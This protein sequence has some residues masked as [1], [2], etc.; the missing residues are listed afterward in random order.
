MGMDKPL[1]KKKWPTKRIIKYS[2]IAVFVL[3]VGY[4]IIF[5]TGGSTLNV[6]TERITV[7]TVEK[8]PFQEYIPI[9]GNVIPK[10]IHYLDASDG[11][12]VEIKY[13]EAGSMVKKGDKIVKLTNTNML[14]TLLN[15]EAEIN[16]ASNDLR[17]T[18]LQLEQ[19][20]L[21]LKQQRTEAEYTLDRFKRE[22]DRNQVLFEQELI[23]KRDYE[24]AKNN[25]DYW[26]ERLKLTLESQEKDIQF[27]EEQVHQ[28]ELS[29]KQMQT[30]LSIVR[31][32]L[33]S[34]TVKAP[35]SGYL[36]S[37]N[38]EIGQAKNRGDRLG[39]IDDIEGFK[40][41]AQIDEHYINRVAEEKIGDFDIADKTF[42]LKIQKIYPE[43]KEGKFEVDLVFTGKVPEGIKRGQTLHIR[44]QLSEASEAILLARGG[45]YQTTGGNWAY[46]LDKSGDF[47]T[48]KPLRLGRQ[49]PQFFE[50]LEG[51]NPGD[52]VITSSYENFGDM[53]RL[54]LK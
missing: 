53:E 16:R 50:V 21:S 33:E 13:V 15:N 32:Q 20:R 8:G 35:L 34:L 31:Q 47:A 48:K 14:M 3:V 5:G 54:V 45:F 9:I 19:N 40:V 46:V 42:G 36:T 18:R 41:R 12:I 38:A 24:D 28:L 37:L 7:S 25:Y 51:L 22:F 52:K 4:L 1:E 23:S 29:V 43:V 10:Y 30:N 11:G 49:N 27:R 26:T 6:R 17:T 2:S 44:L 39:Q